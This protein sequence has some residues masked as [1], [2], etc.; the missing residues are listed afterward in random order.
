[1]DGSGP[2][3]AFAYT[4]F[5]DM[6]VTKQGA[7]GAEHAEIVQGLDNRDSGFIGGIVHGW[8]DDWER[9]VDVDD[10]R[11]LPLHQLAELAVR[12]LVPDSIAEHNQRVFA[13]QLLVAGVVQKH[14]VSMRAQEICF[15]G[16]D[17]VLPAGRRIRIVH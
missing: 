16:E 9:I 11:P 10:I 3:N 1:M 12:L 13:L 8:R 7:C 6:S 2:G 5:A 17:L 14:V 15:L 4:I